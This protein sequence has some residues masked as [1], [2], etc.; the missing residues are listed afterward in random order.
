MLPRRVK[1]LWNTRDNLWLLIKHRKLSNFPLV[2][3]RARLNKPKTICIFWLQAQFVGADTPPVCR[4]WGSCQFSVSPKRI[5]KNLFSI[6]KLRPKC[7]KKAKP[8]SAHTHTHA[9]YVPGIAWGASMATK[10]WCTSATPL[11][12]LPPLLLLMAYGKYL[13]IKNQNAD[14]LGQLTLWEEGRGE[15]ECACV[16]IVC[17]FWHFLEFLSSPRFTA[18]CCC[19][20]LALCFSGH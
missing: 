8:W 13:K 3:A 11:P 9:Q 12:P 2:R 18:A 14:T 5:V 15:R 7:G 16:C 10:H 4:R 17:V 6:K 1:S 19:C 20:N